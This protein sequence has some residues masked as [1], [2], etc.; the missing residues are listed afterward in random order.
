M[1]RSLLAV[2]LVDDAGIA[3]VMELLD[4]RDGQPFDLADVE[5]ATPLRGGGD[6]RRPD[7][8]SRSRRRRAAPH[9]VVALATDEAVTAAGDGADG[10][11][12]DA[13]AIDALLEAASEGLAGDDPLWRLADRIARLRA[14]D[15]DDLDLAVD[16]L[17]AL[18]ARTERRA[19][20][21][22]RRPA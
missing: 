1:P 10:D 20:A 4:R 11:A 19:L 9:A 12:L 3:G 14:A 7:Q 22:R 18:L 8:P 17:D 21:G 15:P 13:A 6:G 5:L 2:P 16:W